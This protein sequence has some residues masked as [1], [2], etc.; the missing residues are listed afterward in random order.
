MAVE[1]GASGPVRAVRT[2][3]DASMTVSSAFAAIV[4]D[5]LQ[6]LQAN[7]D[8]FLTRD[9]PEYL[10]QVRVA[11]RRTRSAFSAF[12]AVLPAKAS[13]SIK[14]HFEWLAKALGPARDWDVFVTETLP[15]ITKAFDGVA[16]SPFVRR[17]LRNPA[18]PRAAKSAARDGDATIPAAAQH[19]RCGSG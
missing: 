4:R 2:T 1:S 7:E 13:A 3:L 10:H 6:H 16:A 14:A 8:G 19:A 15:P 12:S 11:L 17:C 18:W 5:A 9:D